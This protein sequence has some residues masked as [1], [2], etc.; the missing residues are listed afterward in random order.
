MVCWL[1]S[2][3][4]LDLL[5]VARVALSLNLWQ[6]LPLVLEEKWVLEHLVAGPL[7]LRFMKVIHIQLTDEGREVI[8]LKVLGQ[9]LVA[10]LVWLLYHESIAIWLN[11]AYDGISLLVIHDFIELNQK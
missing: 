5:W 9:Y 10:E 3:L 11:P 2:Q 4:L 7:P 1:G 6:Q 8:V